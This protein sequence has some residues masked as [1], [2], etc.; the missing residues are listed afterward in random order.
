[1][2]TAY[3]W[4]R[5]LGVP[6][7]NEGTARLYRDYTLE[8]LTEE[9]REKAWAKARDPERTARS[10]CGRESGSPGEKLVKQS[11]ALRKSPNCVVCGVVLPHF[12]ESQ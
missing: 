10:L 6:Q 5:E 7:V 9:A 12:A 8:R 1:M 4:R 11:L 2:S 3:L